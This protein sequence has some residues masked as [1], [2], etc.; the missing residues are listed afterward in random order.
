LGVLGKKWTLLILRDIA[1]LKIDR[2]NQILRSLP[3]L[4]P[5]VLI[6]RLDELRKSELI[7]PVIIQRR[8]K[9]VRWVLTQKGNDTVPILM[10]FISFGSKWYS[11][12]V[13]EDKQPRTVKEI[14]P[15]FPTI[16]IV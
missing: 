14:F 16:R 10:S 12:V 3:G 1:F 7:E 11:D 6:M 9:L 5:R 2:F 8:P 13:F 4:T 15:E